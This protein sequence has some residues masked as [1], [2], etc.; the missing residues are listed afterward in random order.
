MAASL[1][2]IF[3]NAC[4][5]QIVVVCFK[6]HLTHLSL[7]RNVS[8]FADD[9]FRCIFVN[10][11]FGFFIKFHWSLLLRVQ[12]TITQHWF[13]YSALNL[14]VITESVGPR[15]NIKGS[16]YQ[17][18]K[19]HCGDKTVARSSYPHNRISCTG[20]T[21]YLCWIVALMAILGHP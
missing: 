12:L 5:C 7:G 8:H 3:W 18:R 2:T 14:L 19:F 17:F 21:T 4:F 13:R 20:K 1:L 10:E 6:F 9:I 15:F 16:S 11:Q